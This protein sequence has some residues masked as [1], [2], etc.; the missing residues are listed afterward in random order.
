MLLQSGYEVSFSSIC[1]RAGVLVDLWGG[2]GRGRPSNAVNFVTFQP[3]P[4]KTTRAGFGA[5]EK[6]D[7]HSYFVYS[8]YAI[9][10]ATPAA[11]ESDV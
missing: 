5:V 10:L 4:A 7:L 6:L 11:F 3:P 8:H 2:G 1:T 9:N